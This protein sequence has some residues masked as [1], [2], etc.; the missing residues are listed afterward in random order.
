MKY[1]EEF[2]KK[3]ELLF[4]DW[5]QM[6]EDLRNEKGVGQGNTF[7]VMIESKM[8]MAR[9]KLF[10]AERILSEDS[11]EKLKEEALLIDKLQELCDDWMDIKRESYYKE[12]GFSI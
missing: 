1:S 9:E 10:S 8:K 5:A 4:P 12:K 11:L 7:G 6:S 2:I 3:A